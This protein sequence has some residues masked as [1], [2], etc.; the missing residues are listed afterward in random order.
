MIRMIMMSRK[1]WEMRRYNSVEMIKNK[2]I[3]GKVRI[4]KYR[5]MQLVL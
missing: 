4:I 1:R 2:D 3:E 5:L